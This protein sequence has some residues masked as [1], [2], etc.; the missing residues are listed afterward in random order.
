MSIRVQGSSWPSQ[1]GGTGFAK[2][3]DQ[4]SLLS[5]GSWMSGWS[6]VLVWEV[7]RGEASMDWEGVGSL[8]ISLVGV[9]G[10]GGIGDSAS[11]STMRSILALS[12]ISIAGSSVASGLDRTGISESDILGFSLPTKVFGLKKPLRLCCPLLG[13]DLGGAEDPDLTRLKDLLFDFSGNGLLWLGEEVE[14]LAPFSEEGIDSGTE[15]L[16]FCLVD[17]AEA[18]FSIESAGTSVTVGEWTDLLVCSFPV[19][20]LAV[21]VDCSVDSEGLRINM[22]RMLCRRSNSG[23][24]FPERGN[25]S[26]AECS[27][28][29]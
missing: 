15:K 22:S 13:P 7:G 16:V 3:L 10:I 11:S 27:L 12:A 1:L 28:K 24:S 26:C 18:L 6:V 21:T 29:R 20:R 14:I 25:M 8:C 2:S 4:D 19:T 5:M 23:M 17:D 9:G